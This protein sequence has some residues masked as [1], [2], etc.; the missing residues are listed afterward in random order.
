MVKYDIR[1]KNLAEKAGLSQ[2]YISRLRRGRIVPSG[3]SGIYEKLYE[4]FS[5]ILKEGG[6]ESPDL[7]QNTHSFK[8]RMLSES[9]EVSNNFYKILDELMIVYDVHNTKLAKYLNIDSSQISRY[10]SGERKPSAFD[11]IL[12]RLAKYFAKETVKKDSYRKLQEIINVKISEKD[13][14]NE[15]EAKLL[16]SFT[17]SN[18]DVLS[19]ED[20]FYGIESFYHDPTDIADAITYVEGL[21]LP[22]NK[23]IR[24][25]GIEGLKKLVLMFLNSTAKSEEQ[26]TIK[27]YSSQKMDW[28]FSDK[29]YLNTWKVLM[30]YILSKGNK[31]K[32]IHNFSRPDS[33]ITEAFESWLPVYLA[34]NIESY[35]N[36]IETVNV[37]SNTMFINVNNFMVIGNCILETENEVDYYFIS[38]Y[39][40]VKNVER[41]FDALLEESSK[42]VDS[43]S[44]TS[45]EKLLGFMESKGNSFQNPTIY[46]LHSD[47]PLWHLDEDFVVKILRK[48]GVK[49]ERI[50]EIL[51]DFRYQKEIYFSMLEKGRIIDCFYMQREDIDIDSNKGQS[52]IFGEKI[53]FDGEEG[54]AIKNSFKKT[55]VN[56]ENYNALILDSKFFKNVELVEIENERILLIKKTLPF[57]VIEFNS[58]TIT[59]KFNLYRNYRLKKAVDLRQKMKQK[60]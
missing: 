43:Y 13:S 2:G 32:I 8:E 59:E 60:Q 16:M 41:A 10:R 58:P 27:L 21:G 40:Q 33:E 34:G 35:T 3:N 12:I 9:H 28:L 22:N 49:E 54:I 25:K 42:A 47:I 7:L 1:N 46:Y 5:L 44:I 36:K 19:L 29:D 50:D 51:E 52:H 4:A 55:I 48:N 11:D 6:F 20:I 53:I 31:I 37:F 23:Q 26:E 18:P 17:D 57:S 24:R 39:E 15:I 38:E 45:Y 14:L 56:H 30:F